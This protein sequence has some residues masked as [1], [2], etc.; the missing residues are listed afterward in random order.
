MKAKTTRPDL[1]NLTS[2]SFGSIEEIKYYMR[3]CETK[4]EF[5]MI[6][7]VIRAIPQL[8][9]IAEM[10]FD[11]NVNHPDSIRFKIV[12]EVLNGIK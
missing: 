12:S 10:F 5:E 3:N 7:N 4:K 9:K 2:V 8:I 1:T 6:D 11:Q